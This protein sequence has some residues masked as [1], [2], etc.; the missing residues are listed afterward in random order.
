MSWART[1]APWASSWTYE[2][3]R[4]GAAGAAGARRLRAR[5]AGR[6]NGGL[7][8]EIPAQ[9]PAPLAGVLGP[10]L[11]RLSI[12]KLHAGRAK[13]S[14]LCPGAL[15]RGQDRRGREVVGDAGGPE[16]RRHGLGGAA[17]Q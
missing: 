16:R 13:G 6:R 2:A 11:S 1:I 4:I 17:R 5:G 7:D 15:F 8:V 3:G 10:R 9:R 12:R 14:R